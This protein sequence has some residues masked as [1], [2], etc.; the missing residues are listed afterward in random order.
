MGL[1]NCNTQIWISPTSGLYK[2]YDLYI[3]ILIILR[4]L[5]GA[6][7]QQGR[8]GCKSMIFFNLV[9]TLHGLYETRL[10][11]PKISIWDYS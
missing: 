9:A 1:T 5:Q 8:K 6:R 3:N 10:L 7:L 2:P 4:L 11:Q